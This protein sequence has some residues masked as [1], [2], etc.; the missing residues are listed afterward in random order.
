MKG[1]QM[2]SSSILLAS[3]EMDEYHYTNNP[4]NATK[5]AGPDQAPDT[6]GEAPPSA[7]L[8][9]HEGSLNLQERWKQP[10]VSG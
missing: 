5:I 1:I 10:R 4:D 3:V 9:L 6:K 8:A 7:T 2:A